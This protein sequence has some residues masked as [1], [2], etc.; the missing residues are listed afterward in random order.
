MTY[1]NFMAD[2]GSI[3]QRPAKW[4]EMFFPEGHDLK[5]N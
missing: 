5:G 3:K 4:Q 1:A 2:V